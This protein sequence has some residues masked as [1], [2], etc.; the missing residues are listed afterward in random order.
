VLWASWEKDFR[1][2]SEFAGPGWTVDV[3]DLTSIEKATVDFRLLQ[4]RPRYGLRKSAAT[5]RLAGLQEWGFSA[6]PQPPISDD[7]PILSTK[8]LILRGLRFSARL[9]LFTDRAQYTLRNSG[10][11]QQGRENFHGSE[12]YLT[13]RQESRN[14]NWAEFGM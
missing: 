14:G 3:M 7:P 5:G 2:D 8:P 4:I 1:L 11:P 12:I 6:W 13:L 9:S 10:F